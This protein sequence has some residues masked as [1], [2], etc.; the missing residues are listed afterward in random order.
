M[1]LRLYFLKIILEQE[2]SS[3]I[4]KFF[5]NL[6]YQ[7]PS[8][9]DW[10]STC[11]ENL[12]ELNLDMTLKE[13][14]DMTKIK[15]KESIRSKCNELAYKY[16]MKR[17]GSKGKEIMYT[18]IEMSQ[19]L[20]PNDTLE[21]EEQKKIFE[22][23][24]KMTNIPANFSGT[25]RNERK[26]VCEEPENMEHIYCCKKLNTTDIRTEYENIYKG[27]VKNMKII[28][29]RFEENLKKRDKFSHEIQ[30]VICQFLLCIRLTIDSK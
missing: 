1:K 16:L 20:Q 18:R 13:I 5:I 21:I 25:N 17:K 23:R 10:A 6:Q 12:K 15:Y 29:N 24:N 4:F 11:M 22:I 9:T 2:K 3:R 28:L 27:N 19:Y 8:K 26:C 7:N 14:K 30:I